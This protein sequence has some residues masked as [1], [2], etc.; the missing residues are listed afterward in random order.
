M[1]LNFRVRSY[2]PPQF[3]RFT[4]ILKHFRNAP[5]LVCYISVIFIVWNKIFFQP[6]T[7]EHDLYMTCFFSISLDV[8]TVGLNLMK[9]NNLHVQLK[10]A[11]SISEPSVHDSRTIDKLEKHFAFD[12]LYFVDMPRLSEEQ[13]NQA[14]GMLRAGVGYRHVAQHFNCH[15]STISRLLTRFRLSGTTKDRQRPGQPRVTTRR[16][17]LYIRQRHL[18]G[19]FLTSTS[20]AR[21]LLGYG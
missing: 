1:D 8:Y 6:T 9:M 20:T 13:R 3:S 4:Y 10:Y 18:R 19:R 21:I 2:P 7:S 11:R 14:L 16:Q 5:F 17:D 12:Q 15:H